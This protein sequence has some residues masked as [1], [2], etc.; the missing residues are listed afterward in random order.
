M[1][2]VTIEGR[3]G[4]FFRL[5]LCALLVW[6][7]APLSAY[8]DE[9]SS[10]VLPTHKEVS[11]PGGPEALDSDADAGNADA[12]ASGGDGDPGGDGNGTAAADGASAD[13]D[14]FETPGAGEAGEAEP[15]G[16][17]EDEQAAEADGA[18]DFAEVSDFSSLQAAVAAA[19]PGAVIEV[20]G[21]IAFAD[22]IAIDKPLTIKGDG[23]AVL[24]AA[25]GKRHFAVDGTTIA[26]A[27]E[28][29][30]ENMVFEGPA[31]TVNGK[32]NGG[33]VVSTTSIDNLVD[34]RIVV[35]GCSFYRNANKEGG[36]GIPYGGALAISSKTQGVEISNCDFDG[37]YAFG[38]GGAL[39]MK[40]TAATLTECTFSNNRSDAGG[41]ALAGA[42]G[43]A[44]IDCLF[45]DNGAKSNGGAASFVM[46]TT[47]AITVQGSTF[48]GNSAENSGGGLHVLNFNFSGI[49]T[50]TVENS[51]F[52]GNEVTNPVSSGRTYLGA[53]ALLDVQTTLRN[54]TAVGNSGP[55]AS[56]GTGAGIVMFEQG[57]DGMYANVVEGCLVVGNYQDGVETNL[58]IMKGQPF[59]A[60]TYEPFAGSASFTEIPSGSTI[61]DIVAVDD[62]GAAV[63]KDNGGITPTVAL[64]PDGIAVDAYEAADVTY[65]PPSADQRGK[66]RPAGDAGRYDAGAFEVQ[67]SD[68]GRE[69]SVARLYGADRYETSRAV[70]TYGRTG[71]DVAILAS[72]DDS[73]FPDALSASALSGVEGNA[74]IVLTPTGYLSTEARTALG[75]DLRP[76]RVIIVGD[77]HAVSE[78]VEA[79]VRAL[80]GSGASVERIGG[81]DRQD[82]ADLIYGTYA[83]SLSSTAILAY[84][85]DFPD[86][87]SVSSWAAKTK[88]PIFLVHFGATALSEKTLQALS[89]GGFDRILVMGSSYSVSNEAVAQA[90][91]ASGLGYG[92]YTRFDGVDRYDTSARFA[93]WA[94]SDARDASERLSMHG[95]AIVRGDIHPDSLTG[96]ALQGRDS[97][98]IVLTPRDAATSTVTDLLDANVEDIG[99]LRFFGDEYA[100][101]LDVVRHYIQR[102][103]YTTIAWLPDDSVAVL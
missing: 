51:T 84:A 18:I 83:S 40:S 47:S 20:S 44:I 10:D 71:V 19:V 65:A 37:N 86:A 88:S 76:S 80:L 14:G 50:C 81:A 77:R 59:G 98:V 41:G 82:T 103:P 39:G 78:S 32:P 36:S 92:D 66:A 64:N 27:P 29:V 42:A 54:V 100:V 101:E 38:D 33:I 48:A 3:P 16:L 96:G 25:L 60:L 72:G 61:G 34:A 91:A 49:P 56:N 2:N 5:A 45:Q 73:H 17:L 95:A 11:A 8:A 35:E 15:F 85:A 28:I 21:A 24:T 26:G 102:I 99:E 58:G 57:F 7:L 62:T 23:S 87:L 52:F 68:R 89:E 94:T 70:S 4:A 74:P 12:E 67:D 31:S 22:A 13:A 1:K 46:N 93:S 9:P 79:E 97:S 90:L 43:T 75:D 53:A 69:L 30:F 55:D 63:L 6:G